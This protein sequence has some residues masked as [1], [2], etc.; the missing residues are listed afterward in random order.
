[1]TGGFLAF[2][3]KVTVINFKEASKKSIIV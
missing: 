2:S 1:M 3:E